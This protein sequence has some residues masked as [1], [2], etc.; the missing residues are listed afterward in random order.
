MV[1]IHVLE[2]TIVIFFFER[3][4][5]ECLCSHILT[6][7]CCVSRHVVGQYFLGHGGSRGPIDLLIREDLNKTIVLSPAL[8][9]I[10]LC[11]LH[12]LDH[13]LCRE[14]GIVATLM[15]VQQHADGVSA[16]ERIGVAVPLCLW[17]K[18]HILDFTALRR[19]QIL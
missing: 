6:P 7:F 9:P 18:I 8:V 3:V 11:R 13:G 17:W 19:S 5:K 4:E 16:K 10:E 12:Q 15:K 14:I 2:E 1:T